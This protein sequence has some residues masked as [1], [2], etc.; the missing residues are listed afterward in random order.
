MS[1][2]IRKPRPVQGD[3]AFFPSSICTPTAGDFTANDVAYLRL[4]VEGGMAWWDGVQCAACVPI[5]KQGHDIKGAPTYIVP[6]EILVK[7]KIVRDEMA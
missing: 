4:R 7:A 2:P 1:T 6:V 3:A 5:D